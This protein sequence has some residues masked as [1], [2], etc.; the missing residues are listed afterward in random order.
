MTDY[1]LSDE[2]ALRKVNS[3]DFNQKLKRNRTYV[4][5]RGRQDLTLLTFEEL[6]EKY[7][8][9][10]ETISSYKSMPSEIRAV[11]N[12][13]IVAV[14]KFATAVRVQLKKISSPEQKLFLAEYEA[15]KEALKKGVANQNQTNNEC[16]SKKIYKEKLKNI[17]KSYEREKF[18]HINFKKI[19]KEFCGEAQY[20]SMIREANV[21]AEKDINE[22]SEDK[23]P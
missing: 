9:S 4:P 23:Q 13:R 14:A 2:E 1:V 17:E 10:M 8:E 22:M 15:L 3:Q 19:V 20:L 21:F 7:A 6:T 5:T 11:L 16:T 18:I 12:D